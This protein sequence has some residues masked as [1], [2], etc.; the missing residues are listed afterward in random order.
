MTRRSLLRLAGGAALAISVG[1]CDHDGPG[2]STGAALTSGLPL[3]RPFTVPLP[4]P[5]VLRPVRTE[6][7]VDHYQIVQRKARAEILPG[8]RT[9]IWGYNGIFPGP[10][11]STRSNRQ[12]VVHQRNDLEVPGT[13]AGTYST[14]TTWSTRTWG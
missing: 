3:P 2:G 14:A 7:N 10:T 6:N 11:L 8:V 12:I 4:I 5:P 9:E 1:A 13:A